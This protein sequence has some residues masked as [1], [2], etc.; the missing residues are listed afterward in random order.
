MNR[1]YSANY[2]FPLR[3]LMIPTRVIVTRTYFWDFFPTCFIYIYTNWIAVHQD[4]SQTL[5]H[6]WI[7]LPNYWSIFLSAHFSFQYPVISLIQTIW[8]LNV[9]S[10]VHGKKGHLI[11]LKPTCKNTGQKV[12][13]SPNCP[14]PPQL[15]AWSYKNPC[16][17][18]TFQDKK[19]QE[20]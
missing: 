10:Q 4:K 14:P 18:N 7:N 15:Q 13:D 5:C 11:N 17:R 12:A 19:T 3:S 8:P 20:R 16:P 1:T 9:K 2:L 6:E